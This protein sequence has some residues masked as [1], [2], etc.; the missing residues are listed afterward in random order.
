[1]LR[2]ASS[3]VSFTFLRALL[4]MALLF[5]GSGLALGQSR[6]AELTGV[7]TDAQEAVI[8]EALV[9]VTNDA[10]GVKVPTVTNEA[11]LYQVQGLIPGPYRVEVTAKGFKKFVRTRVVLEVGQIGRVD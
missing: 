11:G 6:M 7:V 3:S 8:P 2:S 1:M 10:T 9:E 5:S 4:V